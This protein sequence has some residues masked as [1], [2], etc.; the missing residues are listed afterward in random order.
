M[1]K[2]YGTSE[3]VIRKFNPLRIVEGVAGHFLNDDAEQKIGNFLLLNSNAQRYQKDFLEPLKWNAIAEETGELIYVECDWL[4]D[5]SRN[6]LPA[7]TKIAFWTLLRATP[8]LTWLLVT[9]NPADCL[10]ADWGNGYQNV[11]LGIQVKN[12][13]QALERIEVLRKTPSVFRYLE[14]GPLEEALG[15]INLQGIDLLR[16][17]NSGKKFTRKQNLWGARISAQF[18]AMRNVKTSCST[19]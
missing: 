16:T 17:M 11:G 9:E 2:G 4:R 7:S 12:R 1:K 5:W 6:R 19:F 18:N 3:I 10:P 15:E 13:Q 14:I 8:Y